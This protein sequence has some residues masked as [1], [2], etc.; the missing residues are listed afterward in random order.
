[1]TLVGVSTE[2]AAAVG[3]V[4]TKIDEQR[5]GNCCTVMMMADQL[6]PEPEPTAEY[7]APKTR[8]IF[9]TWT[10]I[11]GHTDTEKF[12]RTRLIRL[13]HSP[14]KG[15]KSC[16]L[17]G[18]QAHR[19]TKKNNKRKTVDEIINVKSLHHSN[20]DVTK[21]KI[22]RVLEEYPIILCDN[23]TASDVPVLIRSKIL[24]KIDCTE[25]KAFRRRV[26][27][28]VKSTAIKVAKGSLSVKIGSSLLSKTEL[29]ENIKFTLRFVED[30]LPDIWANLHTA[31]IFT[32]GAK[33]LEVLSRVSNG[34]PTSTTL[35]NKEKR[36]HE[37]NSDD[38]TDN[39]TPLEERGIDIFAMRKRKKASKS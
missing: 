34:Q 9:L 30:H 32:A 31:S 6:K 24:A 19:L 13:P 15:E 14:Y 4:S 5:L 23:R 10:C 7:Q 8:N 2:E 16:L 36:K 35:N 27:W 29:M 38:N 33:P 22:N 18:S 26:E 37:D 3:P 12:I 39:D 11:E 20:L 21:N 25:P 17:V 1:M 28:G